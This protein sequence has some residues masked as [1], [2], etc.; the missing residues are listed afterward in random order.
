MVFLLVDLEFVLIDKGIRFEDPEC[1]VKHDEDKMDRLK[2]M[3][4]T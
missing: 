3:G 4:K 2:L 1:E